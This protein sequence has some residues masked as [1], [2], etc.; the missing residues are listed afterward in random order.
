MSADSN[1]VYLS[2]VS[3]KRTVTQVHR[4]TIEALMLSC[5]HMAKGLGYLLDGDSEAFTF[6]AELAKQFRDVSNQGFDWLDQLAA[7]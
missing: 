4:D 7:P 2:D 1:V 6:H 3:A 5:H